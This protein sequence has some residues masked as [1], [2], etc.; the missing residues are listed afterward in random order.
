MTIITIVGLVLL[1]LLLALLIVAIIANTDLLRWV[2]WDAK[3][4][5]CIAQLIG[6]ALMALAE[7]LRSIGRK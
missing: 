4:V 6:Y 2:L 3:A 5:E 7:M 1:I